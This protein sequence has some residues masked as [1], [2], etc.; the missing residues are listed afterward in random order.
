VKPAVDSRESTVRRRGA[1]VAALLVFTSLAPA[2]GG[3]AGEVDAK[4]LSDAIAREKG[5]VV[6]VNFWAT[7]CVPC[8][9]EF[10]DL[11][12]LQKAYE[13]RGLRVIGVSTDFAKETAAVEKFLAEQKPSF[14]N[15][16]KKSGGDDQVFIDAVEKSW[17]GE[18]PFSVLY[19]RDGKKAGTLSGKHSYADYEAEIRKLLKS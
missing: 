1:A 12:R 4:G 18:L 15:Y 14:P 13:S 9:E 17:G 8:R 16:R 6:L 10:P 3:I 11:T 5:K 7:W 2:Y 19:G